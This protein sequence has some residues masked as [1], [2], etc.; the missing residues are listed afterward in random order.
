M[1][2]R[3]PHRAK[4]ISESIDTLVRTALALT[5]LPV[6]ILL[7]SLVGIALAL[8]GV[9]A[10]S[11]HPLYVSAC[12]VCLLVGGTKL[13]LRGAATIEPGRAYVVVPNHESG[14]DPLCLV[15]ALP[16]LVMRFVAKQ[17]FMRLPVVGQ[18]LRLTGNVKVLRT[19][20]QG[21]VARI[22]AA[23]QRR[24][25]RVSILFFAEGTRSRDGALHPFKMGAF[26]TALAYGLPILPI[27]IAGTRHVWQ[28][29]VV[30]IR[31]GT[32]AI[33]VGE[34]IPVEGLG[35]DDRKLLRDRTFAAVAA[36]RSRAR[37]RLRDEGVD[38]GGLD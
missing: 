29:S 6:A 28:R 14:W 11:L 27:G 8:A 33:E 22:H 34:P 3:P 10:P 37:Q 7:H 1:Q 17:Q 36:L 18:A 26:A 38:P 16:K 30:R 9:P 12:R 13:R 5:V 2:E 21:D 23:M 32:V 15:V 4:R 20:T 31:K 24:D 35:P 25:P 19:E